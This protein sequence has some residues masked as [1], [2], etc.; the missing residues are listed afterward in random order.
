MLRAGLER[1][2]GTRQAGDQKKCVRRDV[3]RHLVKARFSRLNNSTTQQ[4]THCPPV[5]EVAADVPAAA[6][7]EKRFEQKPQ[8]SRRKCVRRDVERHLSA[9]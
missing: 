8:R 2:G 5:S 6:G 7:R 1:R 3:E 9:R 4:L